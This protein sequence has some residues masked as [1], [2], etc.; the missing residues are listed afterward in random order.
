MAIQESLFQDELEPI[1]IPIRDLYEAYQT[2]VLEDIARRLVKTGKITDAAAWQAQRLVESGA[3]YETAMERLADLTGQSTQD[4]KT[5]FETAGVRHLQY[6]RQYAY[7]TGADK[8]VPLNLSPGMLRVMNENLRK[9]QGTLKNLTSTTAPVA[10]QLFRDTADLAYQQMSTG[11]MSWQEAIKAGI[12]SASAK[13]LQTIDYESGHRDSLDVALR[14]TVLTGISQTAGAMQIELASDLGTDLVEVTAHQ[15][16]RNEGSGA[17]NHASWQGKIYSLSGTHPKYPSLIEKTGYGTGAGLYGWNCRH[18]MYPYF[19]GISTPAYTPKE[20]KKLNDATVSMYGEQVSQYAAHQEQRRLERNV[21][22]WKRQ[23]AALQAAGYDATYE[24]NKVKEWQR[25]LLELTAETGL[26][27]QRWR[28]QAFENIKPADKPVK[29]KSIALPKPPK[30]DWGPAMKGAAKV[31]EQNKA[32]SDVK[33]LVKET[34]ILANLQKAAAEFEDELDYL[35]TPTGMPVMTQD[36]ALAWAKNQGTKYDKI[37]YHVTTPENAEAILKDG[38][39]LGKKGI[40]TKGEALLGEGF[41][42]ATDWDT[43]ELYQELALL[44]NKDQET[45]GF[46]VN[47]Q[48][49]LRLT[50]TEPKWWDYGNN[51]PWKGA[52]P[53]GILDDFLGSVIGKKDLKALKQEIEGTNPGIGQS[54]ILKKILQD[55]G[56]DS[57]IFITPGAEQYLGGSQ[58]VVFD[59]RNV[60]AIDPGKAKPPT[61]QFPFQG[62]ENATNKMPFPQKGNWSNQDLKLRQEYIKLYGAAD[63]LPP[64]WMAKTTAC[65]DNVFY[66]TS[67]HGLELEPGE[68]NNDMGKALYVG[69]DPYATE[70]MYGLDAE[71]PVTY[72][73]EV[74]PNQEF[75][76]LDVRSI[77]SRDA[78]EAVAKQNFPNSKNPLGDQARQD[79]YDAIRYFDPWATGDEWAILSQEKM[80]L[81]GQLEHVKEPKP[82]LEPEPEPDLS[83]VYLTPLQKGIEKGYELEDDNGEA[84]VMKS[85]WV[86]FSD[87]TIALKKPDPPSDFYENSESDW[88]IVDSSTIS[89][90]EA[91]VYDIDQALG[92]GIVPETRYDEDS[93]ASYQLRVD[94]VE[95]GKEYKHIFRTD[96][97]KYDKLPPEFQELKDWQDKTQEGRARMYLLDIISGNVDRHDGNWMTNK[98]GKVVAIDNGLTFPNWK[99]DR[100][101]E[102][103]AKKKFPLTQS[104]IPISEEIAKRY[105][106]LY[107]E[108][109]F[110]TVFLE[111]Q[112][113]RKTLSGKERRAMRDRL[114][115]IDDNFEKLFEVIPDP[116][117]KEPPKPKILEYK[118]KKQIKNVLVDQK[119]VDEFVKE[120]KYQKPVYMT[121]SNPMAKQVM[122]ATGARPEWQWSSAAPQLMPTESMSELV[123]LYPQRLHAAQ[124]LVGRESL[125]DNIVEVY[126]DVRKP[127][128]IDVQA[129]LGPSKYSPHEIELSKQL[130]KAMGKEGEIDPYLKKEVY[131]EIRKAGYDAILYK[132]VPALGRGLG[133]ETVDQLIP[134]DLKQIKVKQEKPKKPGQGLENQIVPIAKDDAE[135]RLLERLGPEV[136]DNLVKNILERVKQESDDPDYWEY[137][138]VNDLVKQWAITSNDENPDS[139][140]VQEAAAKVFGLELTDWQVKKLNEVKK[141]KPAMWSYKTYT[142][143]EAEKPSNRIQEFVKATYHNTQ[144]YLAARGAKTIKVYRGVQSSDYLGLTDTEV[145]ELE[146]SG[147][148]VKVQNNALS[149]WATD[150]EVA[151][152]FAYISG[153]LVIEMEVPI[154]HVF[155]TAMTGNGCLNESEVVL[156]GFDG[157]GKIIKK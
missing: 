6:T 150:I 9:T 92:L 46:A 31:Q 142:E 60:V 47:V 77:A 59:P 153:S 51:A 53:Q 19:E 96:L 140:R 75:K 109:W 93:K 125:A 39:K 154:E 80:I 120:S 157:H 84:G 18:D 129:A 146:R 49:P 139:L 36:E 30:V 61:P 115:Y 50:V 27:R 15:G 25:R 132:N 40:Y 105:K 143:S 108:G 76:V 83:E 41:Y 88:G 113:A 72:Q 54:E 42:G 91:L 117:P 67:S 149:S 156:I 127:L 70:Q 131:K 145:R 137:G 11:T 144:D 68:I 33:K 29:H 28:E 24:L 58:I 78:W 1:L 44:Q 103:E 89:R 34:D 65:P 104:K 82:T 147:K 69:K 56:Y 87:G 123:G 43:V 52:T 45:I 99:A 106:R 66:H 7:E 90:R 21:R 136:K 63:M 55:M 128:E 130:V 101:V 4:L 97:R 74:D 138:K 35:N 116:K 62:M 119:E 100:A 3:V 124:N 98:A 14:R 81:V 126:V 110:D 79:G 102:Y 57:I 37:V 71:N 38:Y 152:N 114:K 13:G 151:K 5:A 121:V 26:D 95:L 73:F 148:P 141:N 20:V 48:K 86:S 23:A 32:G 122:T 8:I 2:S 12:K 133:K 107:S 118:P 94:G 17:E 22:S 135:S 85:S 155:S 112:A 111:T 134:L 10:E 16:A 64:S